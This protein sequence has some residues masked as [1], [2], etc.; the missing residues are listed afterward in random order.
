MNIEELSDMTLGD[1][2]F[3]TLCQNGIFVMRDRTDL[4]R[5]VWLCDYPTERQEIWGALAY[6]VIH[7]IRANG[8]EDSLR[9][10]TSIQLVDRITADR[11]A[12]KFSERLIIAYTFPMNETHVSAWLTMLKHHDVPM[13]Y[14]S[15]AYLRSRYGDDRPMEEYFNS[16]EDD[17]KIDEI[18]Y[19]LLRGKEHQNDDKR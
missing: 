13:R 6:A 18:E 8:H 17:L 7:W 16:T 15:A 14:Y 3:K 4:N 19:S 10:D 11:C 9:V 5:L 12:Y 1:E 2:A